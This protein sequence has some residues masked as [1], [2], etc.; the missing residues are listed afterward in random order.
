MTSH[1]CFNATGINSTLTVPTESLTEL[2]S[3][4]NVTE[5]STIPFSEETATKN[6]P[7]EVPSSFP[8]TK[9]KGIILVSS[10]A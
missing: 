5:E 10:F 3:H 1:F 4:A 2:W 7:T 8:D 9:Y 6:S